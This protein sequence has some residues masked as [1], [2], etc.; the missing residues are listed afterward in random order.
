MKIRFHV[1]NWPIVL[2]SQSVLMRAHSAAL[3]LG[4][5][6][7]SKL[8]RLDIVVRPSAA[9]HVAKHL[10]DRS[11]AFA[12]V[13]MFVSSVAL[14]ACSIA[15]GMELSGKMRQSGEALSAAADRAVATLPIV[16]I[17]A[18][19][20][21]ARDKKDADENYRTA[22]LL[23]NAPE[24]YVIGPADVLQVTVW[25]HPELAIAQGPS[26]TAAPRPADA[27]QGFVVDAD[28]YLQFPY[29]G[30]LKV[31]GLDVDA[32]QKS[33]STALREYFRDPQVTVRVA[34][35]RSKQVLIDGEVH[36]PGNQPLN[37]VPMTLADAI[38]RAGGFTSNAD[39]GRIVLVRA[40][41]SYVL[42]IP[43][44][45]RHSRNPSNI[46][47]QSGDVLRV[48]SRDQSGVYVMGEVAKPI[49]AIPK[50]DGTLSLADA[51]S[52]AGSFNLTTSN[53]QQLYVVRGANDG[54]PEVFHLNA[55]S[56]VAMVMA[57]RFRLRPDDIVYVDATDLVRVNRVLT[58][59]LPAIDAGL[60]AAVVA[61]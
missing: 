25:D 29:V 33:L 30:R 2:R 1:V 44:M 16:E 8:A 18:S 10:W 27:P 22:N 15:P 7:S 3:T 59:L 26:Q 60:T 12:A 28:G 57:S 54:K 43:D 37:D 47:L 17:D 61:K 9:A 20:I 23:S 14:T 35:Y 52:Q 38:G 13:T 41:E 21:A 55:H 56:P 40:N 19:T 53:P 39:Q 42:N 5:R 45:I 6:L 48:A 24:P 50:Q 34:S 31:S 58:L 4:Q 32:I 51:L 49:T 46:M 11:R 36:S